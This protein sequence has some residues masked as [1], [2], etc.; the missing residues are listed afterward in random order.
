MLSAASAL[1]PGSCV[2]GLDWDSTIAASGQSTLAGVLARDA[3]SP[4]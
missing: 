2:G 3:G 4:G 1:A